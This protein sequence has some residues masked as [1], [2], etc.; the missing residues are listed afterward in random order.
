MPKMSRDSRKQKLKTALL[1]KLKREK[2]TD[3]YWH[4][5]VLDYLAFWEIKE[6]LKTEIERKGA[7]ITIKNGSQVFRKRSDAVVEL[8][9]IHKRMTDILD[10][11]AVDEEEVPD[12]E[13]DDV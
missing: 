12:D 13:E 5:L 4:D 2:K 7:M 10:I 3:I 9:K 6:K 11:L 8:P 1:E